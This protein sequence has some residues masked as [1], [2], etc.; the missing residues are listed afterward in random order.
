MKKVVIAVVL[1]L[2]SLT[3]TAAEM[4]SHVRLLAPIDVP[5][6]REARAMFEGLKPEALQFGLGEAALIGAIEF[7]PLAP[8]NTRVVIKWHSI[9]V[10]SI[11]GAGAQALPTPLVSQFTVN[12][13]RIEANTS[14]SVRGDL[15]Q[16]A[17][18]YLALKQMQERKTPRDLVSSKETTKLG[19]ASA[20]EFASQNTPAANDLAPSSSGHSGGQGLTNAPTNSG[21]NAVNTDLIV[22]TW[23]DCAARNDFTAL[24]SYPQARKVNKTQSGTPMSVGSCE[25]H[26]VPVV[27]TSY[28]EDCTARI[29]R[30]ALLVYPQSRKI[31]KAPNG[32]T[33]TGLCEDFGAAVAV[34]TVYGAPCGDV[35]DIAQKKTFQQYVQFAMVGTLRV[36][37]ALCT[38]DFTKY[39]PIVGIPAACGYRHD[40]VN[41][42]SIKQEE[43]QYTDKTG[44]IINVRS[45]D[46]ST[47]AF[48][49]YV[50]TTTCTPTVDTA[51]KLVINNTRVAFK[52][53]NGAELYATA[54]APSATQQ[55]PISEAFCTPKYEHD[56]VNHV[57][58]YVTS[59]YYIDQLGASHALST[60]TRSASN[61]FAHVYQTTGCSVTNDDIGLM[62]HWN[63][64]TQ[65]VT[66]VDG[67]L[68]IAPCAELGSP[69]GYAYL[70]EVMVVA[71]T[72][73]TSW[74]F[75]TNGLWQNIA[76]MHTVFPNAN[77]TNNTNVYSNICSI[78]T[79]TPAGSP[80]QNCGTTDPT[81]FVKGY[82]SGSWTVAGYKGTSNSYY[83]NYLRGDGTTYQDT[84]II[85]N[86][87]TLY[88]CFKYAWQ[89]PAYSCAAF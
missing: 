47:A 82:V 56:F 39:Y 1:I 35:V 44:K 80:V 12:T 20:S 70:G 63:K 31:D 53:A 65:I 50:T 46:D 83:R 27:I 69:T 26:G 67:T 3:A 42:L 41:G 64:I 87:L 66:P 57:S 24:L 15:D 43:L 61:S 38:A 52:D 62:T 9:T 21:Q 11:G 23:E 86:N 33:T 48:K 14:M 19:G 6:S 58:Y 37:V 29:D 25:D 40:F 7:Q 55:F 71:N 36:D 74:T 78:Q 32:Q 84:A 81:L 76:N 30:T 2:L 60:C 68:T 18:A 34:Q 49:Q 17:Q 73:I 8:P 85:H 13:A 59:S 51:N 72:P 88:T 10:D 77:Y 89:A 79:P 45:C 5:K 4:I 22:T 16:V 75:P 28:R 54:C